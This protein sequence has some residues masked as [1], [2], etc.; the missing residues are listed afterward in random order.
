MEQR[1]EIFKKML[2]EDPSNSMVL[3]GLA[4]EYQ[5]C[6]DWH[7]VVA[8]LRRYLDIHDDEGAAYGMLARAL[9]NIGDSLG[10]CNALREGIAA[11]T[12]HGHPS[13]AVEFK[14]ELERFG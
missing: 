10:A 11:A 7:E 12:R 9:E 8:T 6:G 3:F 5:K 14:A 2:E 1:I 13:M 4:N